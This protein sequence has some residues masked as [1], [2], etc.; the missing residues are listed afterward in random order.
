MQDAKK[1]CNM[2]GINSFI[3]NVKNVYLANLDNTIVSIKDISE[4]VEILSCIISSAINKVI[5]VD[6]IK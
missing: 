5:G 1:T 4:C 2:E 6:S 3:T